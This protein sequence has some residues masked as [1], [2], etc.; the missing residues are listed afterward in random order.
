MPAILVVAHSSPSGEV[1]FASTSIMHY[2]FE[3]VPKLTLSFLLQIASDLLQSSSCSS[4]DN[5]FEE[6]FKYDIISSSLLSS[7]LAAP[8]IT[9][10]PSLTPD[11]P[12]KLDGGGG[13]MGDPHSPSD[14]NPDFQSPDPTT[15]SNSNPSGPELS[16][17]LLSIAVV[18]LS[19]GFVLLAVVF[20][21]SAIY[22]RYVGQADRS[23]SD[24][25]SQVSCPPSSSSFFADAD[26]L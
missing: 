23:T 20:V 24:S 16:I 18:F 13:S 3:Y 4:R 21:A 25:L 12:G 2:N 14:S 19:A 10:R 15:T 11:I 7:S 1:T 8:T 6:R 9:P 26:D 5:T 22:V 17:A